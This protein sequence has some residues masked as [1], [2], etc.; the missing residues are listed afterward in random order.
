MSEKQ[1]Q[2]KIKRLNTEI[3]QLS[4]D[5]KRHKA[6]ENSFRHEVGYLNG[7]ILETMDENDRLKAR[8]RELEGEHDER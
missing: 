1:L 4:K 3:E 8:I 5:V 2:N 7:R 6:F